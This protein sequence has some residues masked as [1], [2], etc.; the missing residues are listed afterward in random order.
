MTTMIDIDDFLPEAL[1]YAPNT[2]DVV[3]Q[4]FIGVRAD[5]HSDAGLR[6]LVPRTVDIQVA[7]LPRVWLT[8]EL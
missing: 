3:A 8:S 4:R 1:R 7:G 5:K 2:S 6:I